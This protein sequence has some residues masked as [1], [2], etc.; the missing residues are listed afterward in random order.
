MDAHTEL[1][2]RGVTQAFTGSGGGFY[3]VKSGKVYEWDRGDELRTH[4][5]TS[6]EIVSPT[7]INFGAA[8]VFHQN[9]EESVRIECD[10]HEVVDV[11]I[12]TSGAFRLPNWALGTRWKVTFEG[13]SEVSLFSMATTMRQLGA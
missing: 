1:S 2:D 3:L 6:P 7:P 8:N 4:K 9:G 5:Y 10:G 11:P 12:L 13:K